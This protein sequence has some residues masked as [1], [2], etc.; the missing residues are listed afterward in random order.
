MI[1]VLLNL[2]IVGLPAA[3]VEELV[4]RGVAAN[5]SEAVRMM[6]LHY[7]EHFGVRPLGQYLEDELA[8]E[9]MQALEKQARDGK[10]RTLS[11]KEALAK[12]AHLR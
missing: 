2:N 4:G 7:N 5:K 3:V 11:E 1:C 6:I 8:I 10:R 12:Y 9:K